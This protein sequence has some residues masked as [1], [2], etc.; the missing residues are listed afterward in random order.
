MIKYW[1]S[2]LVQNRTSSLSEVFP[3]PIFFILKCEPRSRFSTSTF[4]GIWTS[5]KCTTG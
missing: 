5:W 4:G 2:S 3:K 1:N